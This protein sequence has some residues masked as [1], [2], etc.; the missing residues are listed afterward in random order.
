MNSNTVKSIYASISFES[1]KSYQLLYNYQTPPPHNSPIYTPLWSLL[2][3]RGNHRKVNIS[4]RYVSKL[5]FLF[6]FRRFLF[7]SLPNF[8][9]F[10]V[11]SVILSNFCQRNLCLLYICIC[12]CVHSHMSDALTNIYQVKFSHMKVSLPCF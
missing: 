8:P 12:V 9:S 2:F 10:F 6:Y 1:I 4:D 3:D 5:S 11:F 7:R